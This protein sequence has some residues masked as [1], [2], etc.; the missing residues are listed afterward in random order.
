M[1]ES[2]TWARA[3]ELI[4]A[5]T[6]YAAAHEMSADLTLHMST[7][8]GTVVTF[9][10]DTLLVWAHRSRILALCEEFDWHHSGTAQVNERMY[11]LFQPLPSLEELTAP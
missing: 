9:A 2:P 8:D 1:N 3:A 10:E 6:H 7:P 5:L 11:L 4:D